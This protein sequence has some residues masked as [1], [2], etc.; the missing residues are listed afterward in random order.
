MQTIQRSI[1]YILRPA[2]GDPSDIG[3]LLEAETEESLAGLA[4]RPGL[5]LV[6]RGGGCGILVIM[7]VV[8]V[9]VVAV[10]IVAVVLVVGLVRRDFFDVR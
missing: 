10:V 4:L 8:V 7:V 3:D 2:Q 5:D 9:V 1:N 6:E